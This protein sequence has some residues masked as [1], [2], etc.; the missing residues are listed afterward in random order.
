MGC[1]RY[2]E[3]KEEVEGLSVGLRRFGDA[4]EWTRVVSDVLLCRDAQTERGK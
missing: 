4:G 3:V 1:V 2:R